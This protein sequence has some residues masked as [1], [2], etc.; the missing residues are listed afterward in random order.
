MNSR[1]DTNPRQNVHE[2]QETDHSTQS[3]PNLNNDNDSYQSSDDFSLSLHQIEGIKKSTAWLTN[4]LINGDCDKLI[5][6]LDTGAEANEFILKT[7]TM[8][9]SAYAWGL[10]SAFKPNDTC[11]N[12][13]VLVTPRCVM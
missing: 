8:K 4:V 12:L 1:T 13:P 9:L 11:I 5:V 10:A 2:M 6:K 3:D 7:T